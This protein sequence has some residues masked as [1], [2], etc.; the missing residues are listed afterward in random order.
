MN[1]QKLITQYENI[2]NKIVKEFCKKQDMEFDFWVGDRTQATACISNEFFF[3]I[4]DMVLDLKHNEPKGNIIDWYSENGRQ[5]YLN[6]PTINY[7][8][9]ING[10][11]VED[12]E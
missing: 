11:R 3:N 12:L 1:T 6:K 2:C 8:S 5:K 9:Y 10:L 4:A 7:Y